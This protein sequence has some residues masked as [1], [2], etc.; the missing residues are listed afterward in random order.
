MDMGTNDDYLINQE[1]LINQF[2]DDFD[3]WN[4]SIRES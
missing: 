3:N 4:K 1:N 2:G